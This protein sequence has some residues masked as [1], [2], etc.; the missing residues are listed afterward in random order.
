MNQKIGILQPLLL[1]ETEQ[2]L[3]LRAYV[4]FAF[5][6]PFAERCHERHR[7][8]SLDQRAIPF[9]HV[10]K[11]DIGAL[12][13]ADVPDAADHDAPL[14]VTSGLKLISTGT[15]CPSLCR[16]YSSSPLPIGRSRGAVKYAALANV[17]VAESLG[18]ENF[19]P[20]AD[21]FVA[22]IAEQPLRLRVDQDDSTIRTDNHERIGNGFDHAGRVSAVTP[23]AG[24]PLQ[25]PAAMGCETRCRRSG[26]ARRSRSILD[27]G[28]F[29]YASG[30][31]GQ[32]PKDGFRLDVA[33]RQ[34]GV[35][36]HKQALSDKT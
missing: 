19:D 13:L 35:V 31:A 8:D 29:R 10:S 27:G 23:E 36:G 9:L 1:G 20:L 5:G 12:A 24:S 6:R 3:D 11:Q 25:R 21:E 18:N 22:A 17:L 32:L 26:R 16:P 28:V 2:F 14:A 33:R 30:A 7:R 34:A 4:Q 15:W